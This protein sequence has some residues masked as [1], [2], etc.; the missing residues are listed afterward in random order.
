MSKVLV[1]GYLLFPDEDLELV[2]K[3][4]VIHTE[5]TRQESGCL[6]F[7]ISQDKNNPNKFVVDEEF[8]DENAFEIHRNRMKGSSWEQATQRVERHLQIT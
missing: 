4:L 6:V 3:E 8:V 2:K 1:K 7:E 5:K